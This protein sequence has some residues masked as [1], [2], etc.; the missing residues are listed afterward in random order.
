MLDKEPLTLGNIG[1]DN[2]TYTKVYERLKAMGWDG[3]ICFFPTKF[4]D[5]F[6]CIANTLAYLLGN[7][8]CGKKLDVEKKLWYEMKVLAQSLLYLTNSE[9]YRK[10]SYFDFD[11][12]EI[13]KKLGRK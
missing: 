13:D 6:E 11:K 4:K 12:F 8:D 9:S 2:K 5:R 3:G 1:L 7:S 10:G